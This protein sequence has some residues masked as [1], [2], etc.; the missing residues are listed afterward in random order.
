MAGYSNEGDFIDDPELSKYSSKVKYLI[1]FAGPTDLSLLNTKGL[2]YDLSKIFSSIKNKENTIQKYN[3]IDYVNSKIPNT[4][5]I[6]SNSDTMVP[7]E[8]S[9]E[10]YD[11]CIENKC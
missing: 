3:P 4:L 8:S 6:H 9:K 7:Y 5:I 2:N 10:L 1:D 11:K